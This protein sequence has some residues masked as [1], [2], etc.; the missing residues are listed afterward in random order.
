MMYWEY[1]AIALI[2]LGGLPH[3]ALDPVLAKNA[4]IYS[5]KY[6]FIVFICAYSF[7]GIL[8]ALFWIN[9]V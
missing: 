3:G 2:V 4:R 9:D 8:T 1:T 6:G 7:I 5:T